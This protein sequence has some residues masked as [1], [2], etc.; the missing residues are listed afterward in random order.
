MAIPDI[1]ILVVWFLL[2]VVAKQYI[3]QQKCVKK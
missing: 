3:L 2:H 1:E